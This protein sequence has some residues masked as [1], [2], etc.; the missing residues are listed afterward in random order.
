MPKRYVILIINKKENGHIKSVNCF[1]LKDSC[2]NAKRV[3]ELF[4]KDFPES[5][6][7]VNSY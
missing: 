1:N 7:K 4:E 6:V 2:L 3:K 5:I